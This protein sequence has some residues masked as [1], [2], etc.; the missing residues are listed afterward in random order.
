MDDDSIAVLKFKSEF[1]GL[2]RR[3]LEE[4]DLEDMDLVNASVELMNEYVQQGDGIE[5]EPDDDFINKL[6]D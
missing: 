2:L 5:F 1:L 6:D 4:S 3:W